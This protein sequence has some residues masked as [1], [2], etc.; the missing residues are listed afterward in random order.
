MDNIAALRL[1]HVCH[2]PKTAS[3]RWD[4]V[5]CKRHRPMRRVGACSARC[6]ADSAEH[7]FNARRVRRM[8]QAY[9]IKKENS[10]QR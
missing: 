7:E 9:G 8:M 4:S 1:N 2:A 3:G 5:P 6:H 10:N